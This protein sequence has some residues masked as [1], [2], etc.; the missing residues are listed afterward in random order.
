MYA[1]T[2]ISQPTRGSRILRSEAGQNLVA[3]QNDNAEE[4]C[5]DTR[6]D[7]YPMSSTRACSRAGPIPFPQFSLPRD[8]AYTSRRVTI[9]RV[10]HAYTIPHC[11]AT[12]NR[13]SLAC[14][15]PCSWYHFPNSDRGIFT[16]GVYTY[17]RVDARDPC[18]SL[19]VRGGVL[20]RPAIS[21]SGPRR[22]P[23][24]R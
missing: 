20:A 6:I 18:P 11:A 8:P 17:G 15:T 2:K 16:R 10:H 23:G 14:N 5:R 19:A 9:G 7:L 22:K 12:Q 1:I 13:L 3:R 4:L 24:A 21:A